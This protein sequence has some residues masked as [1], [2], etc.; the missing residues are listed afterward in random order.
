MKHG[1][2]TEDEIFSNISHSTAFESFLHLLGNRVDLQDF[3]GYS[4]G[5]D[6]SNG[7]NGTQ[8]VYTEYRKNR[9]MFH[10]SSL[11]PNT[12]EDNKYVR[13]AIYQTYQKFLKSA[14]LI[15]RCHETNTVRLLPFTSRDKG[16]QRYPFG[17]KKLHC[18]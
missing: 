1:Q 8:S 7:L 9:I 2:Q 18:R 5:L 4:G 11:M 15:K 17:L 12:G 13:T 16:M 10:V 6:T 14:P 3:E